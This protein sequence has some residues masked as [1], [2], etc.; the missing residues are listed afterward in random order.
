MCSIKLAA[1]NAIIVY[2]DEAVTPQLSQKIASICRALEVQ[3]SEFILDVIPSYNSL[4]ISYRLDLI[5]HQQ[6]VECVSQLVNQPHFA[7]TLEQDLVIIP[8]YYSS[9]TG[10]DLDLLLSEKQLTLSA[11]I[12][13]HSKPEYSV[14]AIGFS[15]A[16][17][18]LGHVDPI[19]QTPRLRTPRLEVPA[20]SVGIA[21]NQTA[22]YP[23]NSAGGWNIV[24]R[25]PLDLSV[26][27]PA[28]IDLFSVGKRIKFEPIDRQ[29]FLELGGVL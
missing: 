16:F 3:F 29:Q 18:F 1:E 22:V 24:G 2:F 20:G 23:I 9:E 7:A 26:H 11:F 13:L 4:F 12:E 21:D 27:N 10:L 5:G 17:A 8:V 25:T 14:F 6:F 19:I 15:P 28:A